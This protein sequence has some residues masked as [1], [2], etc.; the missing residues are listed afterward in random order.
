MQDRV[1]YSVRK[2][3]GA[4]GNKWQRAICSAEILVLLEEQLQFMA[5]N[6]TYANTYNLKTDL[7]KGP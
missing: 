1:L 4:G 7:V 5:V 3:R 6:D 2:E